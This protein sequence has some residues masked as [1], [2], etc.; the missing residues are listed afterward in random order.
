MPRSINEMPVPT[1]PHVEHSSTHHRQFIMKYY[2]Q[3]FS[4]PYARAF[5]QHFIAYILHN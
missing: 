4:I 2:E 3:I 5:V 1:K